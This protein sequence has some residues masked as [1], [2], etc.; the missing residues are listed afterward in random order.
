MRRLPDR[1]DERSDLEITRVSSA[2]PLSPEVAEVA[3]F[4]I[5]GSPKRVAS[6]IDVR[7]TRRLPPPAALAEDALPELPLHAEA[8]ELNAATLPDPPQLSA[9]PP[10]GYHRRVRSLTVARLA[11]RRLGPRRIPGRP[12]RQQ[13]QRLA[14]ARRVAPDEERKRPLEASSRPVGARGRPVERRS[15][16]DEER[17]TATLGQRQADSDGPARPRGDHG[18][19]ARRHGAPVEGPARPCGPPDN[20]LCGARGGFD[21]IGRSPGVDTFHA[22]LEGQPIAPDRAA[23]LV[24]HGLGPRPDRRRRITGH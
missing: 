13:G 9:F 20:G 15:R 3:L 11:G 16:S 14:H 5:P 17:T 10:T 4:I 7:D 19:P 6:V 21:R 2:Q 22:V 24:G 12:R 23:P 8:A 18:R 1:D